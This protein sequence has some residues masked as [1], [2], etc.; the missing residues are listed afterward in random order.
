MVHKFKVVIVQ[1][2]F[3]VL[4]QNTKH[5]Y[6]SESSVAVGVKLRNKM[7]LWKGVNKLDFTL[8]PSWIKTFPSSF[9]RSAFFWFSKEVRP[10]VKEANPNFGVGDIAKELGRRWAEA[11]PEMKAK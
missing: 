10:K 3:I 5:K 6:L 7:E 11:T 8:I 1:I 2:Y 4:W 9:F